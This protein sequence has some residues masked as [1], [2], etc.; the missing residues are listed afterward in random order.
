M[1]YKMKEMSFFFGT[2]ML[3]ITKEYF[4]QCM[5]YILL[6]YATTS[7][8]TSVV[9]R[10]RRQEITHTSYICSMCV[11]EKI[12]I[13]FLYFEESDI[14]LLTSNLYN[15]IGIYLKCPKQFFNNF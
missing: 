5:G 11:C 2:F 3:C 12:K 6:I 4:D 13:F 7:I 10:E 9:E 8:H 15:N 1:S 14:I